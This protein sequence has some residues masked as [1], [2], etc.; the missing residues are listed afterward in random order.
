LLKLFENP[1]VVRYETA[2]KTGG[3]E[4]AAPNKKGCHPHLIKLNGWHPTF[5]SAGEPEVTS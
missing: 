4:S 5:Y 2:L 3:L 1:R